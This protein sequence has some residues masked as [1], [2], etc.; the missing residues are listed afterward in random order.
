MVD[1]LDYSVMVASNEAR[2]TTADH[3]AL[4]VTSAAL[5]TTANACQQAGATAICEMAAD[6]AVAEG[7]LSFLAHKLSQNKPKN[8]GNCCG[9][10]KSDFG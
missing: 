6:L 9:F 7:P 1:R 10:L 4:P 8:A 2:R 3:P 5:V